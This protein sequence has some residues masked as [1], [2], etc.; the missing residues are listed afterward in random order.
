MQ[1]TKILD[2]TELAMGSVPARTITA[3]RPVTSAKDEMIR[4]MRR[5]FEKDG[6]LSGKELS[7]HGVIFSH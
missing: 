5:R 2:Q 4:M 7:D 1:K 3:D 6:E